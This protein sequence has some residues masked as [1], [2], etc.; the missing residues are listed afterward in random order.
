MANKQNAEA[1]FAGAHGSARS[2]LEILESLK[3]E[4]W[5]EDIMGVVMKSSDGT[6]IQ[7]VWPDG[8]IIEAP[9][10]GAHG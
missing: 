2:G 1:G 8:Q 7:V 3:R 4:G 5:Q 9:F 6:L 10:S